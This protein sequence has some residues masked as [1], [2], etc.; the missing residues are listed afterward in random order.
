[1]TLFEDINLMRWLLAC[2]IL[3]ILLMGLSIIARRSGQFRHVTGSNKR[4]KVLDITPIDMKHK[5]A[6][7]KQDNIE[8]TVLLGAETPLHLMATPVEKTEEEPMEEAPDRPIGFLKRVRS[9]CPTKE[10]LMKEIEKEKKAD[11]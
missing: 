2:G 1:M 10:E 7:I 5:V 11:A 3:F 9:S 8:H 4:L 6:I